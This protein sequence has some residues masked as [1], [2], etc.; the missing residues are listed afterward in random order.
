[1]GIGCLMGATGGEIV[2][3][4]AV[5]ASKCL[6]VFTLGVRQSQSSMGFTFDVVRGKQIQRQDKTKR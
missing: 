2:R 5:I 6:A 1:M 3:K 4:L